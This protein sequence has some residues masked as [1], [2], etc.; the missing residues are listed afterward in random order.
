[1]ATTILYFYNSENRIKAK[2][3]KS[4]TMAEV[5]AINSGLTEFE[6]DGYRYFY[7]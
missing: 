7:I 5:W 2:K 6:I 4:R 3:F 1:M